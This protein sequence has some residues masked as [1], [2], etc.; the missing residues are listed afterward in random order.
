MLRE[1]KKSILI[2]SFSGMNKSEKKTEDIYQAK[3]A[4]VI[5]RQN[6]KTHSKTKNGKIMNNS[7]ARC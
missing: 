7:S 6:L 3:W 2:I 4:E 1:K 5:L